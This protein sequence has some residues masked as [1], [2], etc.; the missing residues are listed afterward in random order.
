MQGPAQV[1]GLK[2]FPSKCL[3]LNLKTSGYFVHTYS[4]SG[5]VPSALREPSH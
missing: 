3:A 1:T 2:C 4:V 5:C